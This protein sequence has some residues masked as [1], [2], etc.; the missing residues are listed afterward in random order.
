MAICRLSDTLLQPNERPSVGTVVEA[1][2]N[3]FPVGNRL[4]NKVL[5]ARTDQQG[6]FYVDLVQGSLVRLNIRELGIDIEFTVPATS[7]TTLAILMVP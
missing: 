3:N 5:E 2:V 1:R 4:S 7:T 6:V